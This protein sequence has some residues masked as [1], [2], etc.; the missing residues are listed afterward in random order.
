MVF[1]IIR[2]CEASLRKSLPNLTGLAHPPNSQ[3]L[4][5]AFGHKIAAQNQGTKD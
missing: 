5:R 3:A 4:T 2:N 1:E